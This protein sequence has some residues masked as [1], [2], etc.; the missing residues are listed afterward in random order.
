MAGVAIFPGHGQSSDSDWKHIKLITTCPLGELY[1]NLIRKHGM[2]GNDLSLTW[3]AD[4]VSVFK[5]SKYSI[6]PIQCMLNELPPHLRSRNILLTGL[7]FG[8]VKPNM[9]TFLQP[10]VTECKLLEEIGFTLNGELMCRK[11]FALIC[12]SD[13]PARAMLR[14]SKQFN[15]KYGC[16]WC[17]HEGVCVRDHGGPPTRYYPQLDKPPPLRT[18]EK[19]ADYGIQAETSG[20]PVTGIQKLHTCTGNCQ[21]IQG[22]EPPYVLFFSNWWIAWPTWH[23]H[24]NPKF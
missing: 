11:V 16:D 23:L 14:N 6:W 13:S 17:E 12:S 1:K 9:N 20:E 24:N 7:W 21:F 15:G 19:Q 18:A 22:V 8:Q 4:G 5:S 10:F 3:N 2:T